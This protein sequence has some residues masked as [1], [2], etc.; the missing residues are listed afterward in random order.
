MSD[1]SEVNDKIKDYISE[2]GDV[3]PI[4]LHNLLKELDQAVE[5]DNKKS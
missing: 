3:V 1:A 5:K 2:H 4:T